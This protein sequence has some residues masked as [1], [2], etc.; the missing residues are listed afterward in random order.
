MGY[1]K[2]NLN[3]FSLFW[4]TK[5]HHHFLEA[6][7]REREKNNHPTPPMEQLNGFFPNL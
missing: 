3:L 6:L 4:K 5:A 2:K 7:E 1:K